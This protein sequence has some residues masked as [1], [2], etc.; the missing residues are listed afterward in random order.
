M[1]KRK[2]KEEIRVIRIAKGEWNQ[3][4]VA[5]ASTF[6]KSHT[7]GKVKAICD[8]WL[9]RRTIDQGTT[10]EYRKGWIDAVKALEG[11]AGLQQFIAK[12]EDE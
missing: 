11:Y 1:F 5:I 2:P 6:F 3:D 4:D 9:F 8:E 10:D 12:D 7:F